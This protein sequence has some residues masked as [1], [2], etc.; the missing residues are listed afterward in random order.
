[1]SL[2]QTGTGTLLYNDWQSVSQ[3]VPLF[4]VSFA[5]D[6]QSPK[7]Y[8][9]NLLNVL[10]FK[11]FKNLW[12]TILLQL[13]MIYWYLM[14]NKIISAWGRAAGGRRRKMEIK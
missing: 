5:V 10:L 7:R 12:S 4:C 2:E 3:N 6:K 14:R 13:Y 11:P 8:F 1:M 9:S